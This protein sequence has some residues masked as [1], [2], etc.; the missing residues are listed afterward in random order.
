MKK[1][2]KVKIPAYGV[3]P[4]INTL[5]FEWFYAVLENMKDKEENTNLYL[6]HNENF[7]N[8]KREKGKF[9]AFLKTKRISEMLSKNKKILFTGL[10][11]N[12]SMFAISNS[13]IVEDIFSDLSDIDDIDPFVVA[14]A[15]KKED[16]TLAAINRVVQGLNVARAMQEGIKIV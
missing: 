10:Y 4:F 6:I 5:T 11:E 14:T 12:N 2:E 9:L 13:D 7:K 1:K 15:F 3:N 16:L 8:D